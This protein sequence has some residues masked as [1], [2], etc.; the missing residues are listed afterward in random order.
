MPSL[1]SFL[2]NRLLPILGKHLADDTYLKIC[3]H[4][5]MGQKLHLTP[6]FVY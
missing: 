6:R 3:Y 5:V 1:K 4:I 2:S